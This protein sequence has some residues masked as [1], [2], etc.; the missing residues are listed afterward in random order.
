MATI[1]LRIFHTVMMMMLMMILLTMLDYYCCCC[2]GVSRRFRPDSIRFVFPGR[3]RDPGDF[4]VIPV[5]PEGQSS[6]GITNDDDSDGSIKSY[7]K[8]NE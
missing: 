2:C 3:S 8:A 4:F 5:Q 6:G 7:R 1:I